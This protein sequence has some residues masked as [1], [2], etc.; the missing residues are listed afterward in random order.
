LADYPANHFKSFK[1]RGDPGV[2]GLTEPKRLSI[3]AA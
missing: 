1:D 3:T 2:A